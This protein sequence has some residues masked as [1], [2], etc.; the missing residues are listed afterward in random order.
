MRKRITC[1]FKVNIKHF[2][3]SKRTHM[4]TRTYTHTCTC[5]RA[6]AHTHTHTHRYIYIYIYIYN[7]TIIVNNEYLSSVLL[8][9]TKSFSFVSI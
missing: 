3:T 2:C 6:R 8:D 1:V 9:D 7:Q 4:H 5:V